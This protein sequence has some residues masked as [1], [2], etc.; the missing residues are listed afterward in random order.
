MN[1]FYKYLPLSKEDESWGLIVLNTGR[2]R[3]EASSDYPCKK[4]PTHHDFN[5]K[6]WRRLEEYQVIYITNGQGIFESE[7]CSQVKV[8][9]GTIIFL[10]PNEKH[11][12]KPDSNTGWDE[13]W[14][15]VKGRI[16]D[17]LLTAGYLSTDSPCY[18]IGFNDGIIGLF[19]SII[20]K[21]KQER[22][23]YQPLISGMV[24]HLLG[25]CHSMIKQSS[26]ESSEEEVVIDR[27]RLLFRS[28]I[29]NAYSPEQ[30]ALELHV[31]YSWFRKR[32]KSYTGLSPGQYYLQLKIEKAK[33]LLAN[34]A[35]L[36][37]EISSELNFEST[38]YFSKI[39]KEKTGFNPTDYRSRT[40]IN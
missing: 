37:K 33:E 15:G 4:H 17:N 16:V 14:V 10:F 24:L 30:A 7:S 27:A 36:V 1:N 18:Y 12:Y 9:A 28:N 34:S 25:A 31:G 39:F 32:F 6:S 19:N 2:T 23:G 8:R 11:R 20:E 26:V 13:Y 29:N 3:I 35:M 5:W 22:P 21:T 40:R 38:L